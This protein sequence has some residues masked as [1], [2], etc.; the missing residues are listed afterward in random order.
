M[1]TPKNFDTFFKSIENNNINTF[2]SELDVS[3]NMK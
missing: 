1:L 3:I 2:K